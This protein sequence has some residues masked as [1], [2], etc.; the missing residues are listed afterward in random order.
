MWGQKK[1]PDSTLPLETLVDYMAAD[2]NGD[3]K[4]SREELRAVGVEV[5]EQKDTMQREIPEGFLVLNQNKNNLEKMQ[6]SLNSDRRA[7]VRRRLKDYVERTPEVQGALPTDADIE[8]MLNMY[9]GRELEIIPFLTYR[10]GP[11]TFTDESS[12]LEYE[13]MEQF[14]IKM[15]RDVQVNRLARY[16]S[17]K[18]IPEY[19]EDILDWVES[20]GPNRP[21]GSYNSMWLKL[22]EEY[23]VESSAAARA[24]IIYPNTNTP[25]VKQQQQQ[26]TEMMEEDEEGLLMSG[27]GQAAGYHGLSTFGVGGGGGGAGT[28]NLDG[29]S[30]VEGPSSGE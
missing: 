20:Y 30:S 7:L 28:I 1:I 24:L 4:L 8:N 27:Y 16:F 9:R 23:G 3:G 15:E 6:R 12:R 17:E 2:T 13:Q 25:W 14:L 5:Y 11:E 19:K 26:Q 10:Y 18:N 22:Y 29:P 21:E